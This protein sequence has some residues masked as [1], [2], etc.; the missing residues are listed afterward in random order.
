[1]GG[2]VG[3][4]AGEWAGGWVGGRVGGRAGGRAGGWA[5]GQTRAPSARAAPRE[6]AC[7]NIVCTAFGRY[8]SGGHVPHIG[9]HVSHGGPYGKAIRVC[10]HTRDAQRYAYVE[11][12]G[13]VAEPHAHRARGRSLG[14]APRPPHAKCISRMQARTGNAYHECTPGREMHTTKAGPDGK[15]IRA[16]HGTHGPATRIAK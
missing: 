7:A 8:L 16:S 12:G 14:R 10:T 15:C 1:M 13:H 4:W 5:R 11:W 9:L 3:G 2:W 6:R